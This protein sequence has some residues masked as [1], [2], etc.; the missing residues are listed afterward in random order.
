[1]NL[2]PYVL[3][4]DDDAGMA[5]SMKF[6]LDT[7]KIT[8]HH[9]S[10][11]EAFLEAIKKTPALLNG[12]GC[13]LLDIR[14]HTVSGLDVFEHL[15]TINPQMLMPVSFITG[16]GDVPIVTRVLREGAHDFMQKPIAGEDLLQRI[17]GYFKE[18]EARLARDRHHQ[19]VM[20]R[21]ES[22]TGKEHLIMQ[23]LFEG[24]ANKEIA[25]K[26]GNSV[27]TVELRRAAIYDKLKVKSVVEL[28]R[29][30]ESIDWKNQP[31]KDS[32]DAD[33]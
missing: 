17:E 23:H 2:V 21:V 30:L 24:E 26:L 11:G 32:D 8:C 4:V 14:M 27:R 6:L 15:K 13:I 33:Q 10:S 31:I 5:S 1:M 20:E 7:E 22:L 9:F 12:P 3:F 18:S 29:L 25:E 28:V 16:H 19:E